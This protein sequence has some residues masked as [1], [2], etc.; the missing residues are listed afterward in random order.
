[1]QK[2]LFT[3][4]L[5]FFFVNAQA[6]QVDPKALMDQ[7][8]NKPQ[9]NGKIQC[10]VDGKSFTEKAAL[11]SNGNK[12][13]FVISTNLLVASNI[14]AIIIPKTAT[15]IYPF[16]KIKNEETVI[17]L[18]SGDMYQVI[19]GS[20]NVKNSAGKVSG[21][22]TGKVLKFVGK[23]PNMKPGGTALP[24]TGSFEGLSLK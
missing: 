7:L 10:T 24:L 21:T 19:D 17:V 12:G 8:Q 2:I 15:G 18:A 16:I 6:Q 4:V 1:M 20:I 9:Q 11:I 5:A 14:M 13:N 3:V 23:K 22:F